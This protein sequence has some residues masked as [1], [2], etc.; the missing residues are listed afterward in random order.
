MTRVSS[1]SSPPRRF[2][3]VLHPPRVFA[4]SF[5]RYGLNQ[6]PTSNIQHPTY[7]R[8]VSS[9]QAFRVTVLTNIQHLTSAFLHPPRVFAS[10]LPRHGLT[11]IQHL[12]SNIR[13]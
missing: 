13:L 8:L 5:P 7:T 10:S 1:S 3:S 12:T 6:H 2:R 11:N 9:H 4:S